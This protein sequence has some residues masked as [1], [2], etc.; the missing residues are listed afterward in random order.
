[1][2]DA[3]SKIL[4][5]QELYKNRVP[6]HITDILELQQKFKPLSDSPILRVFRDTKYKLAST[7]A[8]TG[9]S[10]SW[11][12][13]QKNIRNS[14]TF[15]EAFR[16]MDILSEFRNSTKH[17]SPLSA[18][19]YY[20]EYLFDEDDQ[21][22]RSIIIDESKR[23]QKIISDIYQD[24]P[25]IYTIEPRE[26]EEMIAELLR[27]EGFE[28]ELTKQTRDNGYDIL[29]L[30]KIGNYSFPLKF[31]VECKRYRDN[32]PVGIELIRSFKEVLDTEQAN[33]GII[34]TTSYFTR[35]AI[36]KKALTPYLLEYRDKDS[37]IEWVAQY[38][39]DKF[40]N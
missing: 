24:Y 17:I 27:N 39:K 35:D 9:L 31:L 30:R 20:L 33:R 15:T 6:K 10:D 26:F 12:S 34:A 32:R 7:L 23:V 28:V 4:E 21:E 2:S 11:L 40:K 38:Y 14:R 16:S 8:E 18:I 13:I 37:I 29:A 36:A 25:R 22:E 3:I 1:M 5:Q 19:T